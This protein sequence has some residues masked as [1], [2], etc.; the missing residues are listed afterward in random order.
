MDAKRLELAIE[1]EFAEELG[2]EASAKEPQ[3][4]LADQDAAGGVQVIRSEAVPLEAFESGGGIH[5]VA[6]HV[7]FHALLGAE[8]AGGYRPGEDADAHADER[9]PPALEADIE[10]DEALLHR[11]RAIDRGHRLARG[12]LV[13][14]APHRPAR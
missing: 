3:R 14:R 11:Q 9:Q 13:A 7:V 10:R 5:R 12:G 8:A 6:M 4:R 2:L 1:L